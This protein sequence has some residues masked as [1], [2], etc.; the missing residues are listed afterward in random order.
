VDVKKAA[1]SAP[2]SLS[3]ADAYKTLASHRHFQEAADEIGEWLPKLKAVPALG[4]GLLAGKAPTPGR[5]AATGSGD[6]G[7]APIE[8]EAASIMSVLKGFDVRFGN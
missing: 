1:A 4:A 6:A 8:V 5:R 2:L 3:C 7:R